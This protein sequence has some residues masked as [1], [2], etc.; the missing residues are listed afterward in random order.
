MAK[1]NYRDLLKSVF[2]KVTSYKRQNQLNI[3]G[4]S[5]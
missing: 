2:L 3:L 4:Q 1:I 5:N